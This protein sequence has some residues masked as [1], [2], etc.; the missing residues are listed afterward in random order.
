M[1]TPKVISGDSD[2]IALSK[3]KYKASAEIYKQFNDFNYPYMSFY[4]Y[5]RADLFLSDRPPRVS[6]NF[7]DPSSLYNSMISP[8]I[9]YTMKG[10]IWYQGENNAF[11]HKEYGELFSLLISDW[12]KKWGSVFPVSYTHLTLP[13]NA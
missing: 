13:T 1:N 9:P 2:V 5:N 6:Y 11:R 12:R 10:V 3:W 7:N 8:I 4:L